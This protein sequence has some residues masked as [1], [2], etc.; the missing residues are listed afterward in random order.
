M[1]QAAIWVN[2]RVKTKKHIDPGRLIDA[3]AALIHAGAITVGAKKAFQHAMAWRPWVRMR[4]GC[5]LADR[6][7]D[8]GQLG[9]VAELYAAGEPD[10]FE[11]VPVSRTV[12]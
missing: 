6:L 1:R 12:G 3:L 4:L 2:D 7:I 8:H 5:R 10:A 9:L 11:L